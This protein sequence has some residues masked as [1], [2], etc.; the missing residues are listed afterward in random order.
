MMIPYHIFYLQIF[1]CYEAVIVYIGCVDNAF[2]RNQISRS[3]DRAWWI[4]SGNGHHSGQVLSATL[5]TE[6]C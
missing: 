1:Y 5:I 6:T 4:D 3:H 2:A